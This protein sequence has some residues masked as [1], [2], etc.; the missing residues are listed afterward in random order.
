[1]HKPSG[2]ERAIMGEENVIREVERLL[3]ELGNADWWARSK[4]MNGL[5]NYSEEYY[6]PFLGEALRD[7]GDPVLRNA[8][9]EFYVV[10]AGRAVPSLI[11]SLGDE[12]PEA[13]LFAANLLG[14]IADKRAVPELASALKDRE[15]N[16]RVAAAEALG[17]IG[18]PA[19][20]GALSELLE[21]ES[22]VTL[23]S[24]KALGDIGG[25]DALSVLYGCLAKDE[26]R[27]MTFAAIEKAGKED[28][29]EYL[30]PFLDKDDLRELALKAVVT[31]AE[32]E[33]IRL[34]PEYFMS[35]VPLLIE[36]QRSLYPE[37]RRA[38]FIALSWAR[39]LRGL[40]CLIDALID[41]EL[42]EYALNGIMG[43]GKA[44]VPEIISALKDTGRPQRCVLA[45]MISMM[46]EYAALLQFS[47]DGDPEVRVEV[48]LA[49]GLMHSPRT[50]ELLSRML[51]DPEEEVRLVA[52]KASR[53]FE[54]EKK[55]PT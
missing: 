23:S 17:K 11:V 26:Y 22:W 12:N 7:R 20:V 6:L 19:A 1:M 46:G 9:M 30:T 33:R 25:K 35:S 3:G 8:A 29:I 50:G 53:K 28:A 52:R 10:L 24:I 49:L 14:E 32:R 39:D 36:L 2:A 43:L 5:L 4:A 42:Q 18:D 27:G 13:R 40:T 37:I 44:A 38:A 47:E 55:W 41:E 45:K 15:V 48:A 21:D 51:D 34:M 31:I 16:V 54:K